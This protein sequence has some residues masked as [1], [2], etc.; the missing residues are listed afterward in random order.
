MRYVIQRYNDRQRELA[1]R[2]YVTDTCRL[3]WRRNTEGEPPK[4]YAEII[5]LAKPDNRTAEDI[6]SGLKMRGL[7]V[8]EN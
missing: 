5:G 7:E 3:Y 8:T 2:I 6:I 4:R 1:Y